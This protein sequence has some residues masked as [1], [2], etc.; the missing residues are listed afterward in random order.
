MN[1]DKK[2]TLEELMKTEE[3][4]AIL[5]DNRED[6]ISLDEPKRHT[7]LVV[8]ATVVITLLI[9][10]GGYVAYQ[11]Y[12]ADKTLSAEDKI[13][14][15]VVSDTTEATTK[16]T[17]ATTDKI[18]YV[19]APEGLNLRKDA[20]ADGEV[21]AIMPNGTKLTVIETSGDWYKVEYDSKVGWCAKR[22]TSETDPLVYKNATYGFQI[23]FPAT[24]NYKFFPAKA[25]ATNTAS[26]YVALPTTDTA[27]DETS[28]GVDKGYAS[29]FAINIYTP[30][31]WDTLN[32][33]G[34]PESTLAIK[35]TN[36]VIA[37]SLPNGI[38]ANDLAARK[39]EVE[40][41]VGTIKFY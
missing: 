2:A 33:A 7:W 41:V 32:N 8:L 34:N 18:V 16:T 37:Y 21:L 31:Q 39:A 17:A 19:N 26:Y 22:Y 27:I 13:Q 1:R 10:A 36:Y 20:A 15:P 11:S 40:S 25:D 6:K 12:T 28:L 3:E 38:A 23:T 14:T 4:E 29:L 5:A 24:W 9:A 35:N 30:S